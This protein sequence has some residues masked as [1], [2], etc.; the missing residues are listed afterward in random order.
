[1]RMTKGEAIM[2]DWLM[3]ALPERSRIKRAKPAG[4]PQKR[5]NERLAF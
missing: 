5:I 1:M 2:S 3:K 4:K